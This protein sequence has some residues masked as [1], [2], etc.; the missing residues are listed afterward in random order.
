MCLRYAGTMRVGAGRLDRVAP[1]DGV[2]VTD[3]DDFLSTIDR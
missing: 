1:D 2:D 3:C